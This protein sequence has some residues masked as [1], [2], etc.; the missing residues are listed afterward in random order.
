MGQCPIEHL[1]VD[2]LYKIDG[3]D[4]QQ[5]ILKQAERYVNCAY[6]I[7]LGSSSKL[8]FYG[9]LGYGAVIRPTV[10]VPQRKWG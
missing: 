1:S 2:R 7:A 4:A 9:R 3:A 6:L 10:N 8:R 5:N